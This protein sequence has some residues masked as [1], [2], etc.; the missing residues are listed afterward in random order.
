MLFSLL[1][2][3]LAPQG[4]PNRGGFAASIILVASAP[5]ASVDLLAEG[6]AAFAGRSDPARL[7]AALGVYARAAAAAPG[8]PAAELRLARAEAFHALADRRSAKDAWSIASRAAERALRRAAPAW[9]EAVDAGVSAE[10]AASKVGPG[11]AQALYWL[12]LASYS[13]A[14][15]RGFAAVLAVKDAALAMMERAGALDE[16]ADH[17]GPHRALGTWIG[18][19]PIAA[20]GGAAASRRHFD[21]A[22]ALAPAYLLTDVREAE[23]LCVLLQ[24]RRRFETL[25]GHVAAAEASVPEI[26]PENRIAKR[27]AA[28]LL[29]RKDRLF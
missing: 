26:A 12:A 8:D 29:A 23:T 20:G 16:T 24:D 18:A 2:L 6:D 1:A 7:A 4:A 27:L 10:E 3:V 14:Q 13:G 28:G 22:R 5:S 15:A 21:R 9:A 25:L 19:L 17:A 11:G